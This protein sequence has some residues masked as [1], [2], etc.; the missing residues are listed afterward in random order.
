MREGLSDE[1]GH[2]LSI[3]RE[4][5]VVAQRKHINI[6]IFDNRIEFKCRYC[7]AVEPQTNLGLLKSK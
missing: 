6:K 2:I 3:L 1:H 4:F 7:K 5:H